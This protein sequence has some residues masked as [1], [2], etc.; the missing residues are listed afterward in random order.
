MFSFSKKKDLPDPD[1]QERIVAAIRSAESG[2][3]G[4][5]RVFIESRCGYVDAMDRAKEIF[6]KLGMTK[7]Q[8]RNGVLIYLATEDRQFAIM[9]DEAIYTKAGGPL[10]WENAGSE[11]KNYLR[12]GKMAEGLLVCV[13]ELG[14]ALA[15]HFPPVENFHKNELPDEI[16][17]GK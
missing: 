5:L 13:N 12:Q 1:D 15:Q 8:Y 10:F 6:E 3:T 16:I 7:T 11:L 4:E 17:F 9:G 2:S 14:K